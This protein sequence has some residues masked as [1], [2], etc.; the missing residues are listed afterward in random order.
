MK[1]HIC[2]FL[3]DQQNSKEKIFAVG[4]DFSSKTG[5]THETLS[6]CPGYNYGC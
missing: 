5:I 2:Y 1:Y 3:L 6:G 4:D